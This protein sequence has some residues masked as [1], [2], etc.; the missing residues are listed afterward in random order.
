MEKKYKA[1]VTEPTRKHKKDIPVV[2]IQ[3]EDLGHHI[4][5]TFNQSTSMV[6]R[7]SKVF[8]KYLY[9]ANNA[10]VISQPLNK[11]CEADQEKLAYS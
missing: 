1:R 4:P 6:D 7:I 8:S 2:P 5:N 10:N 3:P 9:L 11:S